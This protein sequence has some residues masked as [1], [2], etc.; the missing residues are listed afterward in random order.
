MKTTYLTL[1]ASLLALVVNAQETFFTRNATLSFFSSTPIEDIKAENFGVTAVVNST[2]GEIE[3][4]ALIKSFNFKK[5][6]MQEHFNENYMESEKFPKATFKGKI[7]D[8]PKLDLTKDGT[9]QVTTQGNLT[10]HGVTNVVE[11]PATLIVAAGK[12]TASSKFKVRPEDY[13]IEIPSV[14][15]E[16]I[17]PEIEITV[18]APLEAL[19]K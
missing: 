7:T 6:L 18:D 2:T 9:Y 10:M 11:V 14:V 13:K 1:A 12:I 16:K 4:S 17:A 3:F 19:K 5:A 8:M 15:R